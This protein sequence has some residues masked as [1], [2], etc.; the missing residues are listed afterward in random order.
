[1]S[2]ELPVGWSD[3]HASLSPEA[4][5]FAGDRRANAVSNSNA[6]G[7]MRV[8]HVDNTHAHDN[9]NKHNDNDNHKKD[10]MNNHKVTDVDVDVDADADADADVFSSI[11]L[12][13]DE[14][15]RMRNDA[16][17]QKYLDMEQPPSTST[18]KPSLVPHAH[19]QP[20]SLSSSSS[21]SSVTVASS[22]S[23]SSSSSSALSSSSLPLKRE[24]P[25]SGQMRHVYMNKQSRKFQTS[26]PT[27]PPQSSSSTSMDVSG[28][29][30]GERENP[31]GGNRHDR[32]YQRHMENSNNN[33]NSDSSSSSSN[34]TTSTRNYNNYNNNN[35][36]N[37]SINNI[38]VNHSRQLVL[39]YAENNL[40]RETKQLGTEITNLETQLK[41]LYEQV[42]RYPGTFV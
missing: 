11:A 34:D 37:I 15:D 16:V 20:S 40:K 3:R 29:G 2:Y 23:S 38:S 21:P 27:S 19:A 36:D 12:R 10:A 41:T 18:E 30:E 6:D 5:K 39:A 17:T 13:D 24:S 42:C 25:F 33:N 1:M 8:I 28:E 7:S 31:F 22:S 14:Y 35:N 32:N 9:N 4:M 26:T